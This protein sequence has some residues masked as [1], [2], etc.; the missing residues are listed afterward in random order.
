M[1]N[2]NYFSYSYFVSVHY[3]CIFKYIVKGYLLKKIIT[4]NKLF[5]Y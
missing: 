1:I 5:N 2:L 3:A 4:I